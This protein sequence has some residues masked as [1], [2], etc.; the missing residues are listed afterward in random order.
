MLL[1]YY[2]TNIIYIIGGHY[3]FQYLLL[4]IL[5]ISTISYLYNVQ[6]LI[7]QSWIILTLVA[8]THEKF[9]L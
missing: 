7:Y 1:F 3:N 4:L 5:L 6:T 2:Q 8:I 9:N